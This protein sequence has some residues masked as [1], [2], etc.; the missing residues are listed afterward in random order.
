M[1]LL[2]Y[3]FIY[4]AFLFTQQLQ[5]FKMKLEIIPNLVS[6]S[7]SG[8]QFVPYFTFCKR[9]INEHLGTI[10]NQ[11]GY[12]STNFHFMQYTDNFPKT[13]SFQA[14]TFYGILPAWGMLEA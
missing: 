12:L 14:T 4:E 8:T 13:P 5:L 11:E 9:F 1:I 6:Y 2:I 7:T 3:L 10:I